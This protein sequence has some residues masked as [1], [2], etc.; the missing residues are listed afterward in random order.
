MRTTLLQIVSTPDRAWLTL[1]AGSMLLAREF[2]APGGVL[3]GVLGGLALVL[4]AFGLS[5]WPV[6]VAGATV[7]TAAAGTLAIQAWWRTPYAGMISAAV[8]GTAAARLLVEYPNQISFL[9]ALLT[10]PA[11]AVLAWLLWVARRAYINK[12][13]T[14]SNSSR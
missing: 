9:T 12:V 7:L 13:Q 10:A 6:S 4:A 11:A 3:P 5:S 14:A 2:T 1:L 8:L